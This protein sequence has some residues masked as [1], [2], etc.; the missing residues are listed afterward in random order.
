VHTASLITDGVFAGIGTIAAGIGV[1]VGLVAIF[2][3]GFSRPDHPLRGAGRPLT[4]ERAFGNPSDE[5][6]L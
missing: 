1:G 2:M 3:I 6:E 5:E 4:D